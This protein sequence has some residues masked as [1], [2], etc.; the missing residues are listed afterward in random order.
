MLSIGNRPTASSRRKRTRCQL[1]APGWNCQTRSYLEELICS[2]SGKHLPVI[3][4]FDN[5]I[6]SGDVSEVTLAVL[7]RSGLLTSAR[8]AGTLSPP[9]RRPGKPRVT[10][11]SAADITEYYREFLAPSAHGAADPSPLSNGYVWA[12]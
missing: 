3:F 12:V 8:L 2:G 4:D 6:I 11:E 7:A 1:K 9:F 5:T 10:L